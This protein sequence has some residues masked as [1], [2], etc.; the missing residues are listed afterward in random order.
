MTFFEM[1][2]HYSPG[3]PEI[4][5]VDQTRI[6]RDLPVSAH[7]V[8]ELKVYIIKLSLRISYNANRKLKLKVKQHSLYFNLDYA[9]WFIIILSPN[10]HDIYYMVEINCNNLCLSFVSSTMFQ[11]LWGIETIYWIKSA[12]W[13]C[14]K[15]WEDWFTLP[16]ELQLM[17]GKLDISNLEI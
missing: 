2:S 3:Y 13:L 9:C 14:A 7:S 16:K 11:D 4:Y 17:P 8:L 15:N 5:Y 6:S 10:N 12:Q 1:E